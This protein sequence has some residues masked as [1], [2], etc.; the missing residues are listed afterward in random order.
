MQFVESIN[1]SNQ[2]LVSTALGEG[3]HHY[4]LA[5]LRRHLL[6]AVTIIAAVG[7]ALFAVQST[8]IGLFTSDAAV[9]TAAASALPL[10]LLAFPIDAVSSLLDGTL[11]ASGC[12]P[13]QSPLQIF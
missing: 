1:I 8:V 3:D 5:V 4:A 6:Y 12:A 11:I 9:I 7:A 13:G 2:S 10:L